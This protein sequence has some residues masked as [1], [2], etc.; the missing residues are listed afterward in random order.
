MV[1]LSIYVFS[2]DFNGFQFILTNPSLE[3]NL[4]RADFIANASTLL[5][6][7]GTI[8]SHELCPEGRARALA[9]RTPS[10]HLHLGS[11][12]TDHPLQS[13]GVDLL[14]CAFEHHVA[15]G[16]GE[17]FKIVAHVNLWCDGFGQWCSIQ[18]QAFAKGD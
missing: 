17:H 13:T 3:M 7:L 15:S 6:N 9:F 4:V 10:C 14:K 1:L 16:R 18:T 5:T 11:T 2:N 12:A 8:L